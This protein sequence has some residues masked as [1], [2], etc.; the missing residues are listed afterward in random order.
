V[1]GLELRPS[2]PRLTGV[3]CLCRITDTNRPSHYLPSNR[4][5]GS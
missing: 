5:Q 1:I 3:G 2:K 4:V